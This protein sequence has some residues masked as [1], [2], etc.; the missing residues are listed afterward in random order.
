[1]GLLQ[2]VKYVY[3]NTYME[4]LYYKFSYHAFHAAC[5]TISPSKYL[6]CNASFGKPSYAT[7]VMTRGETLAMPSP[8]AL[9]LQNFQDL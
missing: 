2:R 4:L 5:S 1:M 6:L 9:D 7:G 8:Q 3:R